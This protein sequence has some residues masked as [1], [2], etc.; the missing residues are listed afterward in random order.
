LPPLNSFP[1]F[2]VRYNML[3][4]GR[5]MGLLLTTLTFP[6]YP[7]TLGLLLIFK[8]MAYTTPSYETTVCCCS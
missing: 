3:W 1:F 8:K 2:L 5:A 4:D 7:L 6:L